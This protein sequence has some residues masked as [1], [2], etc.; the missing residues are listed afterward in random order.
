VSN[1]ER[2]DAIGPEHEHYARCPRCGVYATTAHVCAARELPPVARVR[3]EPLTAKDPPRRFDADRHDWSAQADLEHYA[4]WAPHFEGRGLPMGPPQPGA[5]STGDKPTDGA[6]AHARE[7]A[8]AV[9]ARLAALRTGR[10]CL[11][12]RVL[13]YV[14][15]QRGA[16]ARIA[17][18]ALMHRLA[19]AVE[20]RGPSGRR[21]EWA[22]MR[23]SLR[24]AAMEAAGQKLHDAACAAWARG[25]P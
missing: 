1:I 6:S 4:R 12:V 5:A 17:W 21:G 16:E 23:P 9:S 14:Y 24:A 25:E 19:A 20:P 22:T 3:L 2:S 10:G 11:L 8:S 15:L 13:E 7:Y 18:R